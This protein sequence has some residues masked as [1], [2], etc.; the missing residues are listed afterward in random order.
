[1]QFFVQKEGIGTLD[2]DKEDSLSL[3]LSLSLL[4]HVNNYSP[5]F[6]YVPLD[7]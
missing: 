3:S 4:G 2:L 7:Y 5:K 6:L 1:M